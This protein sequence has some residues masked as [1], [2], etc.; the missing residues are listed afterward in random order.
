[1]NSSAE[2]IVVPTMDVAA[3][4]ML[5]REANLKRSEAEQRRSR[6][7]RECFENLTTP[8]IWVPHRAT[9]T[10]A[11]SVDLKDVDEPIRQLVPVLA[12][13][14][15]MQ[16]RAAEPHDLKYTGNG[17]R[18]LANLDRSYGA[19]AEA[20]LRDLKHTVSFGQSEV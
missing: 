12:T 6:D 11:E 20:E 17:V 18:A 9:S 16:R 8:S 19:R 15:R 2:E 10:S 1:M 4:D 14:D 5:L 7:L 13:L 3:V